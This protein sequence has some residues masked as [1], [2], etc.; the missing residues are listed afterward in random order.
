MV[1]KLKIIS[2]D[3]D[4][5]LWIN[6]T[7]YQEIE[8][9]FINLMS[10]YRNRD[11]VTDSIHEREIDN[12]EIYGYGAKGFM[13]SMIETALYVTNGDVKSDDINRIIE[14]GRGLI[15]KP[16]VLL[17][18]V[19]DVLENV[20][21][22]G[23]KMIVATK[24]DLL[25]QERKLRKSGLKEYFDHIEIM[26]YKRESDYEKLIA[27]LGIKP[28]EFLMIGN[29]MKSDILPVLNIGGWGIHVPHHTTWAHELVDNTDGYTNFWEV[30]NIRQVM[31]I[32]EIG[33]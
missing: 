6:E 22:A 12:L 5:T 24:G 20:C 25:D 27:H 8:K 3:A 11:F 32:L 10:K 2:F 1:D 28:D 15:N 26:S 17:D 23:F 33:F 13:L 31:E 9:E 7:Y 30:S 29:S 14:M 4:D 18:G 16:I 21:N 19:C